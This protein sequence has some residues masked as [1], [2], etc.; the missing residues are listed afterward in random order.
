MLI[1]KDWPP[2]RDTKPESANKNKT[3]MNQR[4]KKLHP[5]VNFKKFFDYIC[6]LR[7]F[8]QKNSF[9]PRKT[10]LN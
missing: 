2:P 6:L 8:M 10:E 7:S 9:Y 3:K 4:I 5:E 1:N